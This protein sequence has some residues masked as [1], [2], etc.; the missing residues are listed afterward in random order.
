MIDISLRIRSDERGSLVLALGT[1]FRALFLSLAAIVALAI[2]SAGSVSVVALIVLIVLLLGA[3]YEERWTFSSVD[4]TV[5][6]RY[7]LL[8][9]ARTRHW[10]YEEIAGV[11]F[12]AYRVGSIPGSASSRVEPASDQSTIEGARRRLSRR[13]HL[14]YG[15]RTHDDGLVQ[16]EI[17][18]VRDLETEQ[19]IPATI[20]RHLDVPLEHV[21]I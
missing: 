15:F 18:R 8:F 13:A 6:S 12:T 14:R 9:A 20:A 19:Q 7:G 11:E 1:G 2:L 3:A 17:R 16:I 21:P 10:N 4:S 5:T